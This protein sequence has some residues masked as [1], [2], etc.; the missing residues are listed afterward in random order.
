MTPVPPPSG[1]LQTARSPL[2]GKFR[3]GLFPYLATTSTRTC[4]YVPKRIGVKT[5]PANV[6]GSPLHLRVRILVH[7]PPL[8]R[9]RAKVGPQVLYGNLR[10]IS[11][12]DDDDRR[13]S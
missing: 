2:A 5:R 6:R 7:F 9:C 13:L 10:V 4:T 11:S 12:F 1:D 3:K 8:N